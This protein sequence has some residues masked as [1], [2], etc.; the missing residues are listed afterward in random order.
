MRDVA[1]SAG[2]DP[3]CRRWPTLLVPGFL[4]PGVF[5]LRVCYGLSL[6][7]RTGD[8]VQVYLLGLKFFTTGQWPFF[9]PDVYHETYTQVPGA[10]LGLLVGVPLVLIRQPEAPLILLNILSLAG[11]FLPGLSP[12]RRFPLVPAHLHV[13]SHL[14]VDP[15]VPYRAP[16][17]RTTTESWG[18]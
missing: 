14:P 5:V 12:S 16:S 17:S 10:L 18:S 9:G 8:D 3:G 11:L 13:A 7:L 15:Q 2:R 1:E 4:L 6:E